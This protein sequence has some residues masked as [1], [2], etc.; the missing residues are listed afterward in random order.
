MEFERRNTHSALDIEY[1]NVFRAAY[2]ESFDK[3]KHDRTDAAN[4]TLHK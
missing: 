2:V 4:L 3:L 1:S